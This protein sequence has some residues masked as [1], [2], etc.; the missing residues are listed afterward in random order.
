MVVVIVIIGLLVAALIPKVRNAEMRT[1]NTK[2]KADIQVLTNWLHTYYM[3]Y[4]TFPA[5]LG[6]LVQNNILTSIPH[7]PTKKDPCRLP[8]N[9]SHGWFWPHGLRWGQWQGSGFYSWNTGDNWWGNIWYNGYIYWY[10]NLLS[11]KSARVGARMENDRSNNSYPTV[12][13][14]CCWVSNGNRGWTIA[15][16]SINA[17]K[18]GI[19]AGLTAKGGVYYTVI[20]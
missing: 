12:W 3:S 14:I 17:L 5:N 20:Q 16:G 19:A 2:R 10:N 9:W 1:R 13:C 11:P 18:D 7:D 6:F 15:T 8:E 4:T